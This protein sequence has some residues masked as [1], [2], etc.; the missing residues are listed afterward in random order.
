MAD[1]SDIVERLVAFLNGAK[2]LDG[3]WFGEID[4]GRKRF[5][6]RKHLPAILTLKERVRRLEEALTPSGDTK[7][8]YMGEF[9]FDTIAWDD[10]EECEVR[11]SIYVPW[12][13]VKEIMKAIL[14]R[15]SLDE[16]S[17]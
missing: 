9:K 6:W 14:A 7:A 5:W 17:G 13:T 2:P 15:T 3:L 12:D 1:S 8:A 11:S 4:P 10:E 16:I